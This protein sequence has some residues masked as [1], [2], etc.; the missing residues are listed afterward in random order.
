M[1]IGKADQSIADGRRERRAPGLRMLVQHAGNERVQ[2]QHARF[3]LIPPAA[4]EQHRR[5]LVGGAGSVF[6]FDQ[7]VFEQGFEILAGAQKI[8]G[9]IP[10]QLAFGDEG[11]PEKIRLGLCVLIQRHAPPVWKQLIQKG[12]L[13]RFLNQFRCRQHCCP[14]TCTRSGKIP[15]DWR[16]SRELVSKAAGHAPF[17]VWSSAIRR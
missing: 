3:L 17:G 6:Q 9:E 13:R 2:P 5:A 4:S 10:A 1:P 15:V 16:N 11:Q 14:Y 12:E 8:F 7:L